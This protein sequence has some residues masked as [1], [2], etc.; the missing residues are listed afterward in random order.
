MSCC[1]STRSL[2]SM[3]LRHCRSANVR[4]R[5]AER[6]RAAEVH[7][8][9]KNKEEHKAMTHFKL[10]MRAHAVMRFCSLLHAAKNQAKVQCETGW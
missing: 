7:I 4:R 10:S 1:L 3:V 2:C 5:V 6:R 9:N 8:R